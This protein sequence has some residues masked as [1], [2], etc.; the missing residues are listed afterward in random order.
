MLTMIRRNLNS[1]ETIIDGIFSKTNRD[2][3]V[4]IED[5]LLKDPRDMIRDDLSHLI[6]HQLTMEIR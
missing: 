2:I 4:G 1:D 5:I 3:R 6:Y